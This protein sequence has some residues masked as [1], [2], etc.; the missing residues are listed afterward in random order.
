MDADVVA[1]QSG[2]LEA[3]VFSPNSAT[4]SAHVWTDISCET[5]PALCAVPF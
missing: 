1:A 5:L 2:D 4:S 3:E